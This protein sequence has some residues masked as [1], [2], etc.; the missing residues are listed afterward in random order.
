MEVVGIIGIGL[1]LLFILFMLLISV[2]G[3]IL[4]IW[5][6]VDCL[7]NEPSEGNDKI[8]W[9]LVIIFTHALGGLLYYF[10]RRPERKRL[11]GR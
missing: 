11:V 3:T 10:I 7:S 6:L 8:I 9:A 4:W 2:G 1:Y 5:M